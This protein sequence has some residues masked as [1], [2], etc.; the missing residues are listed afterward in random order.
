MKIIIKNIVLNRAISLFVLG[1][2]AS[3]AH[4][5]TANWSGPYIGAALGAN[6]FDA[7]WNTT[8]IVGSGS[9]TALDATSSKTLSARDIGFDGFVGYNFQASNQWFVGLEA[10]IRQFD[11]TKSTTGIPGCANGCGGYTDTSGDHAA[12]KLQSS[13]S[14]RLRVGYL[15]QPSLMVFGVA[16]ATWQKVT[17]SATCQHSSPDPLCIVTTGSPFTTAEDS[18]TR[19]GW[20]A[21]VGLEKMVAENWLIRAEYSYSDFGKWSNVADISAPASP[22]STVVRYDIKL[23]TQSLFV[24]V[25][26]KFR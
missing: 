24:G 15:A 11:K 6:Q 2:S 9:A 22:G 7:H 26:Y 5:E 16:G 25:A 13:E 12:V 4:G 23:Q 14:A 1:L 19:L 17:S 21:G 18:R 20:T 10:S 3:I 8:G